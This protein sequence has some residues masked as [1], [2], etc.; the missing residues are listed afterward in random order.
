MADDVA[1][2][3]HRVAGNVHRLV[4]V[5]GLADA[6]EERVVGTDRKGVAL[7]VPGAL[8]DQKIRCVAVLT[9]Q[10]SAVGQDGHGR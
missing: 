10:A 6:V 3:V 1:A 2:A 9:H 4:S 7:L 5:H 8:D